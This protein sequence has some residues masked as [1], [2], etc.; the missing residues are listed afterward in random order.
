MKT[1]ICRFKKIFTLPLH[2]IHD[3]NVGQL[4]DHC[5]HHKEQ[6]ENKYMKMSAGLKALACWPSSTSRSGTVIGLNVIDV[7][8]NGWRL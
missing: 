7:T 6:G 2:C 4:L 8:L 5:H 1:I 3:D